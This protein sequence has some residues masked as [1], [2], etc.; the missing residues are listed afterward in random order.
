MYFKKITSLFFAL[1]LIYNAKA[2]HNTS[3]KYVWPKDSLVM[4]NLRGW[5]DLKFGLFMHWGT[6]SQWGIVESWS[7]CPEDEEWCKR[8]GRYADSYQEYVKAYENLQKTFNPVNFNPEKWAAA[9]KE[10]GMKYVVFTTK[11]HDGFCMFDTKETDYK[12][13]SPVCPFSKSSKSNVT[14]EIFNI[15]REK[16]FLTGAYFSKPDW[17]SDAYWWRYFPP[18]NRNATYDPAKYPERWSAFKNFT[19]NQIKELMTNYGK[20]DILWLDGGW[21]RPISSIDTNISWQKTIPFNQDI[22]MPRIAGM[23]RSLQ[24]GLMIVDRTVEG[25]F[26]NYVTPEQTVPDKPLD[27]PWESCITMGKSWSYVP[28]DQY[29]T[30]N[31][32]IHLLINVVSKGGNL[33]LNIGPSSDGDWDPI[34]YQRLKEIGSWMKINGAAIYNSVPLYPYLENN[35]VYTRS[36]DNKTIY[37]YILSNKNE[38]DLILPAELVIE[39]LSIPVGSKISLMANTSRVFKWRQEQG[40][41]FIK[42]PQDMQGK[43]IWKYALVLS[44]R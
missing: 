36:K 2:Q 10:A 24:P 4:S 16:G 33:L 29:K 28:G 22:D 20:I 31:E 26:E 37:I 15:F 11:H 21:V 6:Y 12:I 1:I 38:D 30:A 7:L 44:I 18:K 43:A 17:N 5:Q 13:T 3:N 35:M 34:A 39:K 9:A 23:A 41:T 40:K 14:K 19:F 32:L 25:E 8:Q 27:H 42:I